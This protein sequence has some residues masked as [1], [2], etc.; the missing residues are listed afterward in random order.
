MTNRL[1]FIPVPVTHVLRDA[2]KYLVD[3]KDIIVGD[4]IYLDA[5]VSGIIPADMILFETSPHFLVSSYLDTFDSKSKHLYEFRTPNHAMPESA[6]RKFVA[7]TLP[8]DEFKEPHPNFILDSP[9]FVPMGARL[10]TGHGKGICVKIGNNTIKAL[11]RWMY[12]I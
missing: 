6:S 4:V 12:L 7:Y 10:F 9:N 2:K 8:E 1:S 5:K 11:L 3:S